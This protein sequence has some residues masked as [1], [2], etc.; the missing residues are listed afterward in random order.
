ML[1]YRAIFQA[2]FE[3]ITNE[4]VHDRFFE[5]FYDRFIGS[6]AA[7]AAKFEGTNMDRQRAMLRESLTELLDFCFTLQTNPYI[8]TLARIH[9]SRGRDISEQMFAE[10]LASL[11]ATVQEVDPEYND[12]VSMGWRLV[13]LPGIE[14]MKYFRDR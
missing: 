5:R 13:L 10:W 8:V 4:A 9:G 2:S 1:D 6:D 11:L 7:V 14:F 12:N 3:R